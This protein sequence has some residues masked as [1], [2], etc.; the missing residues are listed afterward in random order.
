MTIKCTYFPITNWQK[1]FFMFFFPQGKYVTYI[2]YI[3]ILLM[4]SSF[5]SPYILRFYWYTWEY[6]TPSLFL[7]LVLRREYSERTTSMILDTLD[8]SVAKASTAMILTPCL[9]WKKT[10]TTCVTF[11]LIIESIKTTSMETVSTGVLDKNKEHYLRRKDKAEKAYD[12][13][14][15]IRLH[16]SKLITVRTC[17]YVFMLLQNVVH[18][19]G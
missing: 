13:S 5:H 2:Y 8:I 7:C 1:Y 6:I 18:V 4:F 10:S 14:R 9:P 19:K 17:K 15:H 12:M 16:L 3:N 11:M